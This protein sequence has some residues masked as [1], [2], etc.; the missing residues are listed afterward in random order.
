[1]HVRQT[2]R[3]AAANVPDAQLKQ[4]V[5]PPG[6]T[7]LPG[8]AVQGVFARESASSVPPAHGVHGS[9]KPAEYCPTVQ[10]RQVTLAAWLKPEVPAEQFWHAPIEALPEYWPVMHATHGV[11]GF[12]SWSVVPETQATH[13]ALPPAEYVPAVQLMHEVLA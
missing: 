12:A 9:V 10:M 6:D 7:V 3:F 8:Q 11:D 1:M 2:L 4:R 5:E 13:E